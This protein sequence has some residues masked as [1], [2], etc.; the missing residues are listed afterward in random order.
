MIYFLRLHS[1]LLLRDAHTRDT[2]ILFVFLHTENFGFTG[3]HAAWLK[4]IVLFAE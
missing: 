3:H 4:R 2:H 1:D